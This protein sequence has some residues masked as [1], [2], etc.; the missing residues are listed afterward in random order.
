M[1]K[2]IKLPMS[3]QLSLNFESAIWTDKTKNITS[4]YLRETWATIFHSFERCRKLNTGA[5]ATSK[6]I[7]IPAPTGTGK[8]L[9]TCYYASQLEKEVG[10]L[11]VTPFI[12]EADE[13]VKTIN[14]YSEEIKAIAFHNKSDYRTRVEELKEHQVLVITHNQF[15]GATDRNQNKVGVDRNKID[16]L[17]QYL[18]GKRSVVVIDEGIETIQETS[19]EY[20]DIHHLIALL[21]SYIGHK[22]SDKEL[23]LKVEEEVKSLE[24]FKEIFSISKGK[25]ND[26][27]E[28]LLDDGVINK[29][30]EKSS[31]SLTTTKKLN[32][33]RKLRTFN[34]L[35]N[36]KEGRKVAEIL[37]N[38]ETIID[39]DWVYYSNNDTL[40]TARDALPED[41]ATVILDATSSIDYYYQMHS[42]IEIVGISNKVRSY[43][44]VELFITEKQRTGQNELTNK[45]SVSSYVETIGRLVNS[46]FDKVAA[47]AVF[48]FKPI[49]ERLNKFLDIDENSLIKL[50][51][52]GN[53]NGK[54]NYR[55]CNTLYIIGTPF[56]PEFVTTNTHILSNRGLAC[57]SLEAEVIEERLSI[58]YSL[59]AADLIQAINRI[60]CRKVIDG[61]GNCPNARVYLTMPDNEPL[62]KTILDAIKKQMPGIKICKWDLTLVQSSRRGPKGKYDK[63][64]IDKLNN[65]T[66]KTSLTSITKEIGLTKKQRENLI[67]RMKESKSNDLIAKTMEVNNI[68]LKKVDRMYYLVKQ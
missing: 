36:N 28:V 48:T 50:D 15:I 58:K 10:M 21:N 20:D 4:A 1:R 44:N 17:Y 52:F 45:D 57:F 9:A 30:M 12:S 16:R 41:T 64:L 54:N 53:L 6:R 18:D 61:K 14:Y 25:L 39:A 2:N 40:H 11:I 5:T 63:A 24:K 27:F 37:K 19:L 26:G 46:S 56:K 47:V 62:S 22:N 68:K 38:L 33:S 35:A 7:V 59:I 43:E 55:D 42:D 51:H 32:K 3:V 8:T 34:K 23:K 66:N 31:L 13:I 65:I 49:E 29:H 67:K 60:S